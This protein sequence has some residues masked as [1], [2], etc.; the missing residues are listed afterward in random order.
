MFRSKLTISMLI[1]ANIVFQPVCAPSKDI[2][3]YMDYD[4]AMRK[5][6][7]I[8]IDEGMP[9]DWLSICESIF[10]VSAAKD[11]ETKR[12]LTR[13]LLR[14][15]PLI[16]IQGTPLPGV[17]PPLEMVKA[18]AIDALVKMDAHEY[19]P[20]IQKIYETTPYMVLKDKAQNAVTFLQSR[21]DM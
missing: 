15:Q 13:I 18:A 19:I 17:M 16:L 8:V 2:T 7:T 1:L 21:T 5:V 20:E 9:V 12:L 3:G 10:R 14:H 6:E 4:D 11:S